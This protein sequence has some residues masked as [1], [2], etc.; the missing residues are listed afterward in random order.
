MRIDKQTVRDLEI[1]GTASGAPGLLDHL[2]RTRT[3][4]GR[5]MLRRRLTQPLGSAEEITAV[6]ESLH[7]IATNRRGFD[8][9]PDETLIAE[10]RRYLDSRFTTLTSVWGPAVAIESWWIRIRYRDLY[11]E[12]RR[13]AMRVASFLERVERFLADEGD[14]PNHFAGIVGELSSLMELPAVELLRRQPGRFESPPRWLLRDYAARETGRSVLG[15]MVELL[16]EV[17]ALVSMSDVTVEKGYSYPVV[18][19][20][21]DGIELLD[22]YHPFVTEPVTNDLEIP[23]GKRLVF[24]TGP[25]M[26]GKT[27]YLKACGITVLLAHVGMGVP[28]RSC[29]LGPVNRLISAIRTQDSLRE[30]ISYFQA[31]ARR[32]REMAAPVAEG[33]R[34]FLIVDELFR[35]TNVGDACDA[36]L[37]VLRSFAGARCGQFLIASHLAELAP[38]LEQY[39]SVLLTR[40]EAALNGANVSFD[41]RLTSGVSTQRLGMKVLE[42]EGVLDT[43]AAIRAGSQTDGTAHGA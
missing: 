24:L 3:R 35:G 10:L 42:Q 43:L 26:A 7:Y 9:L 22:V 40:F 20:D 21:Y 1:M 33:M 39:P 38:Q 19:D 13:G 8:V 6:Q 25:N 41:Y 18:E 30:G 14:L 2:D 17:D 15:R 32:V 36:S 29:R 28:A 16:F 34:C 11:D 37:T 27:T 4:G 23:Q 31:E 12:A 5:E